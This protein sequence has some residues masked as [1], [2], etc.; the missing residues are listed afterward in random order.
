MEFSI[1]SCIYARGGCRMRILIDNQDVDLKIEKHKSMEE[2]LFIIQN[3]VRVHDNSKLVVDISVDGEHIFESEKNITDIAVD[4]IN[5]VEVK[6]DDLQTSIV[7]ALEITKTELPKLSAAMGNI[8]TLLQTGNRESALDSFS[9]LCDE[10]RK[11]IQFFDNI[12]NLL[13]LN[14]SEI[15][16]GD[17]SIDTANKE[18]LELLVDTKKTIENDDLVMLSDLIEY[19]LNGKIKEEIN[20]ADVLI[21]YLSRQTV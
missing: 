7:R 6:T 17:K 9:H 18:L 14:Y 4:T 21:A 19:E 20:I 12:S 11:I 15:H 10:W 16:V 13:H 2:L 1:F 8:S 3:Y 5:T